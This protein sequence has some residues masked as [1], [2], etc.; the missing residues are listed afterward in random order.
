MWKYNLKTNCVEEIEILMYTNGEEIHKPLRSIP[1]AGK[2]N[3]EDGQEVVEGKDFTIEYYR[4]PMFD[5][6]EEY[7]EALYE[8]QHELSQYPKQYAYPIQ[9]KE[10]KSDKPNLEQL[11]W[12]TWEKTSVGH[13]Y[14]INPNAY[15]IG[16]KDGYQSITSN[17]D[18]V[19]AIE[20]LKQ[21][22]KELK[23]SLEDLYNGIQSVPK[24]HYEGRLLAHCDFDK[25]KELIF[26]NK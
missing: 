1:V 23:E 13:K 8:S 17:G 6:E 16:F 4:E 12:Q 18:G 3:W 15:I 2:V 26:K 11:A 9:P 5:S 7:N 25:A 22:N 19:E 20:L 24:S 10:H 14:G 21:E